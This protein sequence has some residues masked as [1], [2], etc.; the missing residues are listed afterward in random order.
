MADSATLGLVYLIEGK[1]QHSNISV[2]RITDVN[3]LRNKIFEADC[4]GLT[5][6][7]WNL[8]LLKART[9]SENPENPFPLWQFDRDD[10]GVEELSSEQTMDQIWQ[11]PLP[12]RHI[13]IFVK[14]KERECNLLREQVSL[15]LLFVELANDIVEQ[16]KFL[17]PPTVLSTAVA[18]QEA[19]KA[20]YSMYHVFL[21]KDLNEILQVVPDNGHLQ[22]LPR[23]QVISLGL[24]YLRCPLVLLVREVY[25]VTYERLKPYA[26]DPAH[27]CGGMVITGQPG[28]GKS[29]FLFYLLICL[30]NEKKNVA[31]QISTEF[32]LFQDT[33][34]ELIRATDME[35]HIIPVGTWA[36]SDSRAG[37]ERP[38]PAFLTTSMAR[39][40]C[41]IQASS[42]SPEVSRSWRRE[43]SALLHWMEAMPLGELIAIGTLFN[44]DSELLQKN[45]RLWGPSTRTCLMLT[46][47]PRQIVVHSRAVHHTADRFTSDSK[48]FLLD[49]DVMTVPDSLFAMRPIHEGDDANVEFGTDH[50]AQIVAH[51]YAKHDNAVRLSFYKAMSGHM[52]FAASAGYLLE[53]YMLLWFSDAPAAHS[54]HCT[55]AKAGSAELK[56]PVCGKNQK[57]FSSVAGLK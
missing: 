44:H 27:S 4:K 43:C 55:P 10:D 38:C 48:Q 50:I 33:G 18:R 24:R 13:H 32:I 23:A 29:C 16:S 46:R 20:A 54:L 42:P 9:D 47:F 22:Y 5:L 19:L 3:T 57:F 21:G 34:V 37:F 15:P 45:Y 31:F 51:A 36:L 17:I 11:E 56:I 28:T 53:N 52:W 49:L 25:K 39:S 1:E 2:P 12:P 6:G 7:S 41:I 26:D 8:T 14:I 35:G 30:L 40:A